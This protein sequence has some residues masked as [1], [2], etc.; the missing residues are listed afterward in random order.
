M[1]L[2]FSD[3]HSSEKPVLTVGVVADTHIPDRV[4]Q[5]HPELLSCLKREQ[6]QLI[7][8]AGDICTPEVLKGLETVAPVVAVR[9]NR[10]WVFVGRLPLVRNL[11]LGG[12]PVTLMH[13][14]GGLY[15][16]IKTKIRFLLHG[17]TFKLLMPVLKQAVPQARVI[18]FGHSHYAE[19]VWKEE[20]L[21]F[22]P[23]SASHNLN[24]GA[25]SFGLLKF[26]PSKKVDGA[27]FPLNGY[28]I[29]RGVWE[30][31]K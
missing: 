28:V 5:L 8:H 30:N 18:V 31:R 4:D 13:G 20:R 6:V 25:T 15:S 16:Y 3:E 11:E 12:V 14:H 2:K 17:Y 24:T 29:Q 9:G 26:Y 1:V 10:D 27:I 19:N 23:G 7:L 21:Y 22:N